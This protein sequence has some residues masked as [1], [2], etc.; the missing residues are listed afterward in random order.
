MGNTYCSL[1]C[2]K[3]MTCNCGVGCCKKAPLLPSPEKSGPAS[4]VVDQ[5]PPATPMP[6]PP[7]PAKDP[8]AG[9]LAT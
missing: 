9:G 6:P 4:K 1:S 7:S 2:S 5:Q 3:L 8:A